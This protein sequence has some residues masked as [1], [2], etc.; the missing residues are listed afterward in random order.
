MHAKSVWNSQILWWDSEAASISC[1]HCSDLSL[2][3]LSNFYHRAQCG[4][5]EA[6]SLIMHCCLFLQRKKRVEMLFLFHAKS[7]D[8]HVVY[9]RLTKGREVKTGTPGSM[10]EAPIYHSRDSGR[11]S[12]YEEQG[13]AG[14][15]KEGKQRERNI[16]KEWDKD[17][18][19]KTGRWWHASL[20]VY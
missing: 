2:K 3:Y 8:C 5:W 12:M 9:C 7:P 16:T 17:K 15:S 6:S 11:S 14:H 10:N 13:R 4:V 20:S 18:A 1:V 19:E